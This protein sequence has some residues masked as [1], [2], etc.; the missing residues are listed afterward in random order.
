MAIARFFPV[1]K[2][3]SSYSGETLRA[4]VV[5]GIVLAALLIP[6]G[7]AYAG[8][9]GCRLVRLCVVRLIAASRRLGYIGFRRKARRDRR[10]LAQGDSAKYMLLASATAIPEVGGSHEPVHLRGALAEGLI[11]LTK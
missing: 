4:D 5:A 2:S 9:R 1:F 6:E 8:I 7:M 11:S 3:L 10:P